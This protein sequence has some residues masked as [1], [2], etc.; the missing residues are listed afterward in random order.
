MLR[1]VRR[2][3]NMIAIVFIH[4]DPQFPVEARLY[5][6]PCRIRILNYFRLDIIISYFTFVENENLM[7]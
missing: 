5:S 7:T 3:E 2:K 4:K 6:Q 1:L